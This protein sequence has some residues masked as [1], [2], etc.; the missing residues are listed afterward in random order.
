MEKVLDD[1]KRWGCNVEETIERFAGDVELFVM[2]LPS[3]AEDGN[4]DKLGACL[5]AQDVRGA[6]EC[7]HALKGVLAN[8]GLTPMQEVA[9]RIVEPLRGGSMDGVVDD[10]KLLVELRKQFLEIL[11]NN[12]M[13]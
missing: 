11:T 4:F 12:D 2:L 7:A 13:I 3:M 1:L 6:F 8:M 5:S 10:Y 9:V